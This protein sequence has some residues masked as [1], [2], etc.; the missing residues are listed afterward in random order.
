M[1]SEGVKRYPKGN[2]FTKNVYFFNPLRNLPWELS[3]QQSGI[4]PQIN[5]TSNKHFTTSIPPPEV[6]THIT[7]LHRKETITR[8]VGTEDRDSFSLDTPMN[9][10]PLTDQYQMVGDFKTN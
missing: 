8:S 10:Q 7:P 5:L 3:L 9:F 6:V 2:I 4:C 1:F